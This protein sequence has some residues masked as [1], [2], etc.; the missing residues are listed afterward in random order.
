MPMPKALRT[1]KNLRRLRV[2]SLRHQDSTQMGKDP[3]VQC[4]ACMRR[5]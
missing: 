2:V 4:G 3:N 5:T 1:V